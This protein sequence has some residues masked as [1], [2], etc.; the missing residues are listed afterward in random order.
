MVDLD[1][2]G[3]ICATPLIV[4]L[5]ESRSDLGFQEIRFNNHP[6]EEE[7]MGLSRSLLF[8]AL[9]TMLISGSASAAE[10]EKITIATGVDPAASVFYIARDAGI[11]QK[12]GFDVDLR[13][14]AT[15]GSTI[16]LVISGEA[17]ASHA[18]SLTGLVNHLTDP[19]L[20]AVAQTTSLDRWYS[21]VSRK[22][23]AS[24]SD[25]KGKKVALALGT[26]SETL[27]GAIIKE[28]DLDGDSVQIINLQPPEMVAALARGDIDAYVAWEPWASKTV[29]G[30]PDTHILRDGAG[31]LTDGT[32]IYMNRKWID[33]NKDAATRFMQAM[34][35]T[36]AFIVEQPEKTKKLVGAFLNIEPA[37]MD[38]LYAKLSYHIKLD[39]QSRK[40]TEA[41]VERLRET[42]RLSGNFDYDQ[43]FYPDLLETA[44]P[45]N[46]SLPNS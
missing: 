43:W 1:L 28:Y 22:D 25:L 11:L 9:T 2:Y 35:E 13:T 33:E 46:V 17:I 16:P 44:R 7:I 12:Y 40:I 3:K 39:E 27:W 29:L 45:E 18:A 5:F 21:I 20:V 23:V 6:T 32:F 37:L 41:G 10:L 26:A 8:T 19:N 42:G 36:T 24:I 15:A 14:G 4:T 38:A 34:V 30:F 31:L